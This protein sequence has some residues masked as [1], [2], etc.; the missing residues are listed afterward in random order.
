MTAEPKLSPQHIDAPAGELDEQSLNAI[1]SIL[2]EE[3]APAPRSAPGQI[4][5]EHIAVE[6]KA[7]LPPRKADGLPELAAPAPQEAG[8]P[9]YDE[10]PR[11]LKRRLGVSLLTRLRRQKRPVA[12]ERVS[13]VRAQKISTAQTAV[14][15]ERVKGYRPTKAHIALGVL[16]LL[17]LF[18]P[19]LMLGIVFL[20]VFILI[21][22]LLM[23][24]YDGFWQGVMRA[25]RWYGRRR[26]SRSAAIHE[27]LDRFAMR[28]DAVL[29]KFPE[30][31]VDSLYLPDFSELATA[32]ARHDA[33][34][35]RRLAGLSGKGA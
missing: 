7:P 29:D 6:R 25:C 22:V 15:L 14:L 16:L 28:W 4:E 8:D 2:I 19:W 12:P 17:I 10:Q 11:A 26:P 5:P 24:G 34:L 31:T 35:E 3:E 18:R 20:S 1:R 21:G 27:R 9:F 23:V 13:K 33:A 32:D 30:G